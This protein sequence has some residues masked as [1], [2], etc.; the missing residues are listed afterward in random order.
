M[1]FA[2]I[3]CDKNAP[4]RNET[5]NPQTL[6]TQ[7]FGGKCASKDNVFQ[8]S[9]LKTIAQPSISNLWCMTR[10]QNLQSAISNLLRAKC[11]LITRPIGKTKR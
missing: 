8:D 7:I 10:V 3:K 1:H 11:K 4:N 6:P 2:N 5:E 9:G